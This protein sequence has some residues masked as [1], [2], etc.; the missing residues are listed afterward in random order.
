V[1][2]DGIRNFPALTAVTLSKS[3]KYT[4]VA[5]RSIQRGRET[6]NPRPSP[7]LDDDEIFDRRFWKIFCEKIAYY[8]QNERRLHSREGSMRRTV[9]P[10]GR[11]KSSSLG[12]SHEW[13]EKEPT[14]PRRNC[15]VPCILA[16][17]SLP[18]CCELLSM[19]C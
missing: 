1:L 5:S 12:H 19:M 8:I 16:I 3:S 17:V 11:I 18:F 10:R 14:R 9:A 6:R 2:S 7:P 4:V 13:R 15:A